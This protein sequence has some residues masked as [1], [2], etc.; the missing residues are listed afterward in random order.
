MRSE[1]S[2]E[3]VPW[4]RRPL[5]LTILAGLALLFLASAVY[6]VAL[7]A[8]ELSGSAQR[9]HGL[10][11][12]LRI[13]SGVRNQLALTDTYRA[14]GGTGVDT[15]QALE[16]SLE[17]ALVG[18]DNLEEALANDDVAG[19]SEVATNGTNFVRAAR[20]HIAAIQT[21][22]D[23]G[24]VLPSE[25]QTNS[26]FVLAADS[27]DKHRL[28]TLDK[29]EE[30]NDNMNDVGST[31]GFGVA[32]VVPAIAL[33]V[34]EALRRTRLRVRL[35][36]SDV[37]ALRT[38]QQNRATKDADSLHQMTSTLDALRDDPGVTG[39]PRIST[40]LSSLEGELSH[41]LN[42]SLASGA[43][44]TTS[45]RPVDVNLLLPDAAA[46]SGADPEVTLVADN[47]IIETDSSHLH[48][49]IVELLRNAR[50]HGGEE[51]NLS[52]HRWGD[53][54]SIAVMD[55]GPGLPA[56]VEQAIFLDNNLALRQRLASGEFG[57]GLLAVRSLA[58]S[59]GAEFRYD[60]TGQLSQFSV[61]VPIGADVNPRTATAAH[62]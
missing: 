40:H 38:Q 47:P 9:A 6:T 55:N 46:R 60:R 33:Y 32:F 49:I 35:A 22:A 54:M 23:P 21:S 28:E 4:Y 45:L 52:A 37:R 10:N 26:A 19:F 12:T 56:E 24:A 58:E 13:A 34:F 3:K 27:L 44:A 61:Q 50:I 15:S 11:E 48:R 7:Q 51:I 17:S 25:S 8:R 20:N 42:R 29:M 16:V 31:A 62:S 53:A 36:E 18:L 30:I 1:L 41:V 59:L 5:F 39:D 43:L 2:A 57:H 14:I